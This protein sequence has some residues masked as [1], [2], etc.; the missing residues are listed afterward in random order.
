MMTGGR[1]TAFILLS[2]MALAGCDKAGPGDACDKSSDCRD[3]LRC[4][5]SGGAYGETKQVCLDQAGLSERC[6][7]Q[8][9][10]GTNGFCTPKPSDYDD[11]YRCE[12]VGDADCRR[13]D[14]CKAE[15]RC[16]YK[17][18]PSS[19]PYPA[20]CIAKSEDDCKKSDRCK[21]EGACTVANEACMSSGPLDR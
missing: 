21:D 12:L 16:S 8:P 17:A 4:L 13:S 18:L 15:G 19:A 1:T 14:G 10:C 9:T 11:M 6:Q 5:D 3:G 20:T 7:Q 2:L